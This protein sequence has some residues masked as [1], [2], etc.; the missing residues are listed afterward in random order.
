MSKPI[1]S[2]LL[3][4]LLILTAAIPTTSAEN[5]V[6]TVLF[7]TGHGQRFFP[8]RDGDLDLSGLAAVLKADGIR[9]TNTAAPFTDETLAEA[10]AVIIS[11]PFIPFTSGEIEALVAYVKR[12]GL[13]VVMLHIAPPAA[14]LIG[15]LGGSVANGVVREAGQILD[16]NPLNFRV[17]RFAPHP[18]VAGIDSFSLYGGWPLLA[19]EPGTALIANTSPGAWVDLDRDQK[20]SATDAV[21]SFGLILTGSIGSGEFAVFADDAIFQ[22]KFLAGGNL[23]LAKNL[24]AWIVMK[25]G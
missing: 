2:A 4:L 11:G 1:L 3:F 9:L 6:S 18:L 25:R 14:T 12:G 17:T 23:Q 15:Q 8:D 22:N 7:D 10:R 24:A 13:L 21:Q 16:G 19:R 20:L 5:P